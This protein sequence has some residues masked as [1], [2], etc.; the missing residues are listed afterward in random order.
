MDRHIDYRIATIFDVVGDWHD[1][2][3]VGASTGQASRTAGKSSSGDDGAWRSGSNLVRTPALHRAADVLQRGPLQLVEVAREGLERRC[4]GGAAA[5]KAA[6]A[7]LQ[8][9]RCCT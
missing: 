3:P 8:P 9:I 1:S 6:V 7:D 4:A 2:D 5:V